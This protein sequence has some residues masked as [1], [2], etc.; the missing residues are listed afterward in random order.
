MNILRFVL[1]G[2]IVEIN[3]SASGLSPSTTVLNYLRSLPRRK[4]TK[5]GCAEGDCGACTVVVGE[6]VNGKIRYKA[7]N[8]CLLFLPALHGRQLITVEDL[9]LRNGN[10]LQLHP[11]QQAIIDNYGSQCGF[12]TPGIVMTL[13]ALYKSDMIVSRHNLNQSLAGN[14]CRCTGYEPIIRA[15]VAASLMRE[16]DHFDLQEPEIVALLEHIEAQGYE[17]EIDASDQKY[18]L[19][20]NFNK[21]LEIFQRHPQAVIVSGATDMAIKQNIWHQKFETIIDLSHIAE[22]QQII[23][24]GQGILVGAG[25][26]IQQL[27]TVAQEQLPHLIPLL[28]VFASW[29]IRNVATVGGNLA[30]AS[31]V[32]D[33]LPA[34]IALQARLKL[35]TFTNERWVNIEEFITGYRK[36]CLEPGE[37]IFE[38]FV[39]QCA[40]N[41]FVRLEKVSNRKDVDIS[42]VSLAMRLQLSPDNTV[43]NIVLAFGGMA[44]RPKRARVTEKSF[45][46]RKWSLEAVE[47]C[48][49]YIDEDFNPIS[50]ARSSAEYRSTVAKNLLIKMLCLEP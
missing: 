1:D 19:P 44:D 3:F 12:C 2:K 23:P 38:I 33:L 7:V 29:Q 32:G 26:T 48:M 15:A 41:E 37:L 50:D 5:E 28:E 27:I 36:T 35:C 46:G 24:S 10:R 8:S 34:L 16:P 14:L 4:G 49:P 18:F 25:V 17:L 11:V 21:A 9:A 39:P 31:P 42:T 47:Y 22:M 20:A 6:I 43:H 30:N 40:E 45:I 13:F